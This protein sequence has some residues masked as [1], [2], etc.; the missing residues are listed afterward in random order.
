MPHLPV[1]WVPT[2]FLDFTVRLWNHVL[3][4]AQGQPCLQPFQLPCQAKLLCLQE[5][6]RGRLEEEDENLGPKPM[7]DLGAGESPHRASHK[8]SPPSLTKHS[9]QHGKTPPSRW[10]S[11]PY[12]WFSFRHQAQNFP[13]LTAPLHCR[14]SH[15]SLLLQPRPQ[16][17][18]QAS[19]LCPCHS[20]CSFKLIFAMRSSLLSWLVRTPLC[21]HSS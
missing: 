16:Q 6:L 17:L 3:L 1:P 19:G 2:L 7:G 18:S 14:P 20:L 9:P 21:S 11:S 15:P 10:F 13:V 4:G 8:L 12:S 5:G